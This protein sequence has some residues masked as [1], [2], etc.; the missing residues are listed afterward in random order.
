MDTPRLKHTSLLQRSK[1]RFEKEGYR[2]L[3]EDQN[4]FKLKGR[5]ATLAGKPDLVAI[6][7]SEYIIC[8]VKTGSP[9]ITHRMQV[10]IYMFAMPLALKQYRSVSFSGMV[11]YEDDHDYISSESLDETFSANLIGLINRIG[12]KEPLQRVPSYKECRWCDL[13]EASCDA[14]VT[15]D[16]TEGETDIF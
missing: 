2:V 15:T 13:T 12:G 5:V 10:M 9:S 6:S 3:I 16:D 14:R 1:S 8:D 4:S 7:D 11:M